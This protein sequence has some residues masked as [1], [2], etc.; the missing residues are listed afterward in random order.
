MERREERGKRHKIS[1][2]GERCWERRSGLEATGSGKKDRR[3]LPHRQ[4]TSKQAPRKQINNGTPEMGFRKWH[5]LRSCS[6]DKQLEVFIR[7]PLWR[8][9][10]T[11]SQPPHYKFLNAKL[12]WMRAVLV[13]A[14]LRKNTQTDLQSLLVQTRMALC[15]CLVNPLIVQRLP[16]PPWAPD[17]VKFP[18]TGTQAPQATFTQHL[19]QRFTLACLVID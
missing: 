17:K 16:W 12:Y 6:F 2:A 3:V 18:I 11:M 1:G 8:R 14:Q 5:L 15:L 10:S 7:K 13:C 19:A 4:T 9:Q